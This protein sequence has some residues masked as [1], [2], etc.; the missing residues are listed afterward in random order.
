[1]DTKTRSIYIYI[2]IY[3][4]HLWETLVLQETGSSAGKQSSCN[5]GDPGLIPG[6]GSSPG[7]GIGYPVQCSW[8]SL[9]A[10]LVKSLPTVQETWV[11][12][13]AWEDSLEK[14]KATRSSILAWRISRTAWSLGLQSQTWLGNW[15]EL[16]KKNEIMPS[17]ATWMDLEIIS[18]SEKSEKDKHHGTA[19]MWSIKKWYKLTYLQ[20]RNRL[21]DLENELMVT[22]GRWRGRDRLGVWNWLVHTGIFK[23][24]NQQ[25]PTV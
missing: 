24:D 1:M 13:V 19:Y 22:G 2:Y 18:V 15:T 23:I 12:S 4:H 25:G 16:I 21:T 20:N 8:V 7:E 5:T 14:E 17:K 3:I 10:Q 11:Q 9:V 6:S